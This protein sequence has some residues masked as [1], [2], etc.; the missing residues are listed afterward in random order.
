ME[1]ALPATNSPGSVA[2]AAVDP[3]HAREMSDVVLRAGAIH[4][5]TR[6]EAGG[7]EMPSTLVRSRIA[8]STSPSAAQRD[9]LGIGGAAEKR[10]KQYA[11]PPARGRSTSTSPTSTP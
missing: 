5:C 7:C 10:P 1:P 3:F 8:A 2:S 4:R 6:V 11:F 9:R